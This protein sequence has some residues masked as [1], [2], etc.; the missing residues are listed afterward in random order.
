M[1]ENVANNIHTHTHTHSKPNE[2][3][4]TYGNLKRVKYKTDTEIYTNFI[5]IFIFK[6]SR[7]LL[8]GAHKKLK[9]KILWHFL[10]QFGLSTVN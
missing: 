4:K 8:D 7:A 6:A 1:N 3:Q 2:Q 10:F 9:R 5:Y